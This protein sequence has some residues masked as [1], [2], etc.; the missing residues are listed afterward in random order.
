MCLCLNYAAIWSPFW[1]SS[2]T[3][4]QQSLGPKVKWLMPKC[5]RWYR[6]S[7]LCLDQNWRVRQ[8]IS[9]PPLVQLVST[10]WVVLLYMYRLPESSEWL[11]ALWGQRAGPNPLERRS[12]A[13][14]VRFEP[15]GLC[16]PLFTVARLQV[17]RCK[18]CKST[19]LSWAGHICPTVIKSTTSQLIVSLQTAMFYIFMVYFIIRV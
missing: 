6:W 15:G 11:P 12:G 4:Q 3:K 13:A 2:I 16:H 19:A 9:S 18:A 10:K 5:S 17:N 8:M 1:S 7:V 14:V